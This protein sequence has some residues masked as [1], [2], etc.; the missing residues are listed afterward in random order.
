M[1]LNLINKHNSITE[2]T[3]HSIE[4]LSLSELFAKL[5]LSKE[6]RDKEDII[7]SLSK[8]KIFWPSF[9]LFSIGSWLAGFIMSYGMLGFLGTEYTAEES[10]YTLLIAAAISFGGLFI[11]YFLFAKI[12]GMFSRMLA[13]SLALGSEYLVIFALAGEGHSPL[14][15]AIA[16]FVLLVLLAKPF[17]DA[18]HQI[19]SSAIFCTM[20]IYALSSY[21][22]YYA[23]PIA[24]LCTFPMALFTLFYPM[25]GLDLRP[26]GIVFLLSPLFLSLYNY[27]NG[28]ICF[29]ADVYARIIYV[30]VFSFLLY[31]LW[32][33]LSKNGKKFMCFVFIPVL[34]L[35]VLTSM[36]ITASL[37]IMFVSYMISS[38]LVFTV[39]IMA[40]V[41]FSIVFYVGLS[42]PSTYL[43]VA[44]CGTGMLIVCTSVWIRHLMKGS[45]K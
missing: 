31:L 10:R 40:N 28:E 6:M 32:P 35:G 3:E 23:L 30:S 26:L 9:I 1:K 11:S 15:A 21:F 14:W 12:R 33:D 20:L 42:L 8:D 24:V 38:R 19:G 4:N 16:A 17:A 39:G 2:L 7:V 34:C 41:L 27:W 22:F 5:G 37:I 29:I 36:G 43:S 25:K 13:I 45:E 18:A 44:L